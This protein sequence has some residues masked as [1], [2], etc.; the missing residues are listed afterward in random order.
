[1]KIYELFEQIGS[2]GSSGELVGGSTIPTTSGS[3]SAT[4]STT[5]TVSGNVPDITDPKVQAAQLAKQKN[6]Q[7]AQKKAIQDQ[8]AKLQQQLASLNTGAATGIV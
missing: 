5:P 3:T 8:I 6:Q 2:V 7:L 1:M 4:A